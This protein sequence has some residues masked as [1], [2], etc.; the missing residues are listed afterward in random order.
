MEL[1]PEEELLPEDGVVSGGEELWSCGAT[2]DDGT[3]DDPETVS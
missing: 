2:M 1:L 3:I